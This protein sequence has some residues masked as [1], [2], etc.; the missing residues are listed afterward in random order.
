MDALNF[1]YPNYDRLDEGVG[2]AKRKRVVCILS[3][4][5]AQSMKEDK[6]ALKKMKTMSEP[7]AL[8][9]K[10][11][12]LVVESLEEMKTQDVLKPIASPSSSA[13]EVS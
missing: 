2:G 8:T 1:E 5:V 12:K 13:A 7:K 6:E 11:H 4:Q 9:P 10:K 3:R